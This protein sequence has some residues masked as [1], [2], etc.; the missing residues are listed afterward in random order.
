MRILILLTLL[1]G[2]E[3]H[4]GKAEPCVITTQT[5]FTATTV[6][7]ATASLVASANRKCLM[8][9][10]LNAAST[11]YYN[12]KEAPTAS[13]AQIIAASTTVILQ[14]PPGNELYFR[15]QS[16]SINGYVIEGQ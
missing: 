6:T 1:F 4:A 9:T 8:I 3:V 10:N 16:G 5:F 12:F 7:G 2:V 13:T 11:M 15:S 14:N